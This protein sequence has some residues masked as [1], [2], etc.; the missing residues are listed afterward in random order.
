M[1]KKIL[2]IYTD[3]LMASTSHTTSTGLSELLG[4]EISHDKITRFLASEDFDSSSL[5][6]LVKPTVKKVES[7][8]GVLIFDDTIQEKKFMHENELNC[9]HWDHSKGR[10]VKG[11]NILNCLYNNRDVNIPVGYELI[12]KPIQFCDEKTGKMRRKSSKN[13]NEIFRDMIG[14]AV[15]NKIVFKYIL[16]DIW[17]CSNENMKYIRSE[18]KKDF[19]IGAK[20]NRLV[21]LSPKDKIEGSSTSIGNL[22]MGTDTTKR[23]WIEGLSFPVLLFK[24]VFKNKDGSTGVMYLLCSDLN[25]TPSKI[26]KIY[27][28]RWNVEE[29]HKSTKCNTSLGKSPASTVRTQ[30]N[31]IFASLFAYFKFELLKIK[32]NL[33]HFAL[34]TK[35]Y[36]QALKTAYQELREIKEGHLPNANESYC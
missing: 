6:K 20:T 25:L 24:K 18:C 1:D 2:E 13:K 27:Q 11:I 12:K 10:N 28:R 5:W 15:K 17:F 23:V 32:T 35:I 26:Y 31:H 7:K 16:A 14:A 21:F 36:T 19:I 4:G 33:N 34:K 8:E 30:G 9:H 29:Y 3:Y 22:D